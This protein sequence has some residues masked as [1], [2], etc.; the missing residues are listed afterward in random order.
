MRFVLAILVGVAR[1]A[2]AEA[3]ETTRFETELVRVAC[4]KGGKSAARSAMSVFQKKAKA[5]RSNLDCRSCHSTMSPQYRLKP[6]ALE[7]FRALGGT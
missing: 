3:C 6:T 2:W 1:L 7:Q 4:E 5:Q